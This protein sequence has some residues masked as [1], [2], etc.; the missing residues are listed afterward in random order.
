MFEDERITKE[1]VKDLLYAIYNEFN[2]ELDDTIDI[3]YN[4]EV[5]QEEINFGFWLLEKYIDKFNLV[6]EDELE[7]VI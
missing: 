2:N 1:K 6:I 4:K 7:D 3:I 5:T